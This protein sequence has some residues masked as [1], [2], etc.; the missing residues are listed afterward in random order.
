MTSP[1]HRQPPEGRP[2]EPREA[3]ARDPFRQPRGSYG[4]FGRNGVRRREQAPAED[5]FEWSEAPGGEPQ[6]ADPAAD[7]PAV[8]EPGTGAPPGATPPGFD[9]YDLGPPPP[10]APG[11]DEYD[12]GAPPPR[13]Y[14]RVPDLS[15]VFLIL[16]AIRRLVPSDLQGQFNTLLREVLKTIRSLIDWYLE[17]L[18]SDRREPEVEDIPID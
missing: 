9:D 11:W 2:G 13:P 5:G 10:R 17:R 18:D 12:L 8:S 1:E 6:G 16:D 3:R 14:G 4:P 15:P 7:E